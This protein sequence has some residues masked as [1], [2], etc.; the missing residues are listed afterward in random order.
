MATGAIPSDPSDRFESSGSSARSDRPD[1]S[2]RCAEPVPSAPPWL[3][4]LPGRRPPTERE[5]RLHEAHAVRRRRA[6]DVGV[7]CWSDID[8]LAAE[9]A[10]LLAT[11]DRP[12]ARAAARVRKGR[13]WAELGRRNAADYAREDLGRSARWLR[14]LAAVGAAAERMPALGAALAGDDGAPPLGL[15]AARQVARVADEATLA[16]WL[17]AA[18]RLSAREL[19]DAA[20]EALA[21][22]GE[23]GAVPP[24]P[25]PGADG[26]DA[27]RGARDDA[28]AWAEG[29]DDDDDA[30]RVGFRL[31]VP[32]AARAAFEVGVELHRRV[33]GRDA[34]A[35]SF[36]EALCAES[37]GR[38]GAADP[39]ERGAS[40]CG[41]WWRAPRLRFFLPTAEAE[42]R[43]ERRARHRKLG[44]P[45]APPTTDEAEERR[46]AARIAAARAALAEDA[47]FLGRAGAD[48]A[49]AAAD[50]ARLARLEDG[51]RRALAEFLVAL[52]ERRRWRAHGYADLGHYAE[53]RL[54]LSR[55]T[56]FRLV[57]AARA[58]EWS[59]ALAEADDRGALRFSKLVLLAGMFLR[60]FPPEP[61]QEEWVAAAE[62][63]T[64]KRLRDELGDVA[65]RRAPASAP[66]PDGEW[67]ARR[68]VLA[69]GV[70]REIVGLAREALEEDARWT[71]LRLRLPR[72]LA[73][74]FAAAIDRDAALLGVAAFGPLEAEGLG[75]R[76]AGDGA[77]S[78]FAASAAGGSGVSTAAASVAGD[79]GVSTFAA[80]AA[81]GSGVSTSAAGDCAVSMFAASAAGD[82]GVSTF[83]ASAAGAW[84]GLLALLCDYAA[85][86]DPE[87]PHPGL[88]ADGVLD[89]D[90]WRCTAPGC[91]ARA[92]LEKHHVRYRSRG[93]DDDPSNLTTLCRFHHRHGEHGGLLRVRGR[94]P[95]ALRFRLGNGPDAP[96]YADERLLASRAPQDA[97]R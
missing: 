14:D 12:L 74:R 27:R 13:L 15:F 66:P 60:R 48:D 91:S 18:R 56:A 83:A 38:A 71:T 82:C 34:S 53:A 85:T 36:V 81:G 9:T 77:V 79:C 33:E 59:P 35:T 72:E 51:L 30:T 4:R 87:L 84:V 41:A 65:M 23:D 95:D 80:S 29:P 70:R 49:R 88:R 44:S 89:R 62:G 19:R 58:A 10:R 78:T 67:R 93:G 22:R 20:A 1:S 11:L 46:R 68:R 92:D 26:D 96:W 76:A 37:E 55:P 54:G 75:A 2:E 28:A 24:P 43:L 90:G 50:L 52:N 40:L 39:A 16:A 6:D 32:R 45:D 94:A 3:F 73:R 63:K 5:L 7:A 42:R 86:W 69:G 21:A 25:P 97:P 31:D 8:R 64:C 61:A 57:L 47:A 17:E